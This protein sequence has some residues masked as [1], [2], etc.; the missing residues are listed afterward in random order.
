MLRIEKGIRAGVPPYADAIAQQYSEAEQAR[1]QY[2]RQR[3]VAGTPE[4][5]KEKLT[6]MAAAYN[7]DEL[8]IVTITHDFADRLRSYELL[9]QV[10]ELPRPTAALNR[11]PEPGFYA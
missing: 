10:F 4:Q 7:V 8:V 11:K 9:A 6:D 3:M 5:V 2:N 1:I